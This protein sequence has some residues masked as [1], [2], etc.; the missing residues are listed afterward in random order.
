[1][2][3]PAEFPQIFFI[4]SKLPALQNA[5][6][7]FRL[8]QIATI[9]YCNMLMEW[10]FRMACFKQERGC[11]CKKECRNQIPSFGGDDD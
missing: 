8:S 10:S 9:F 11:D 3:F 4:Q 6:G 5:S 1:M 7:D 2:V